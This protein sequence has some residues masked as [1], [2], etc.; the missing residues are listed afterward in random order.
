M[1]NT[2]SA[3]NVLDLEHIF[4]IRSGAEGEGGAIYIGCSRAPERSLMAMQA[5]GPHGLHLLAH[6]V[7]LLSDMNK[8][9]AALAMHHI[10]NG[11]FSPSPDVMTF[12]NGAPWDAL[13]RAP[14]GG[15]RLTQTQALEVFRLA[16]AA[17]LA[18]R[19]IG[20]NYG[21]STVSVGQI[22]RGAVYGAL[23]RREPVPAGSRVWGHP[24][25]PVSREGDYYVSENRE[26][27]PKYYVWH[28]RKR[29]GLEMV[30][31]T[32]HMGVP[33]DRAEVSDDPW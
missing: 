21:I 33:R 31:A 28:R 4:F 9:R 2:L 10:R 17:G 11:W 12:V 6:R 8:V 18:Y 5:H 24:G 19:V 27:A 32:G 25:A 22:A 13:P 14:Q 1:V 7:G 29:E 16:H 23:F 3:L 20:A 15:R 26:G 30:G